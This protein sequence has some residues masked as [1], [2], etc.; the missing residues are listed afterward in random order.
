MLSVPLA[1]PLLIVKVA[2][3]PYVVPS[4]ETSNPVGAV[5][6]KLAVK[7]VPET[8]KLCTTDE[9]PYVVVKEVAVAAP[10]IIG[11]PAAVH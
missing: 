1:E 6:I 5:A 7:L 4:A 9:V 3:E 11:E 8:L 10:E 2:V